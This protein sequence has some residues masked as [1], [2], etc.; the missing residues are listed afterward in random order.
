MARTLP[1]PSTLDWGSM[2]KAEFKRNELA[3]ELADEDN[4][5]VQRRYRTPVKREYSTQEAMAVAFAA[6]RIN[7]NDYIKHLQRF[8]EENNPPVF[9]NKDLVKYHFARGAH[10]V[11][12]DFTD[13][14]PT[15]EDYDAVNDALAHFKNYT[16]KVLAGGLSS[17]QQDVLKA[18]SGD[19]VNSQ[20]LGLVAYVPELVNRELKENA[21]KKL[22]RT[23]YHN[24]EHIGKEKDAIEGVFKVLNTN[25]SR[26]WESHNYVCDYM[27]NIVSFMKA[28]VLEVGASYKFKAKVRNHTRNNLFDVNETRLNY[29]KV[30]QRV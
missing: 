9:P 1:D 30:G 26:K 25:Y 16:F 3:F 24:S 10:W 4:A 8:S 7:G 13:F 14:E 19:T 12:E 23:E 2:S 28:D 15:A 17:F 6:Y 27:G 21:F 20:Q 5:V 18:V 11:P 29:V 22:L